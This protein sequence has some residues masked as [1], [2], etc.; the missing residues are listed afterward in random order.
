MDNI[1][2]LDCKLYLKTN[3]NLIGRR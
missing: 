3:S 1:I 2:V